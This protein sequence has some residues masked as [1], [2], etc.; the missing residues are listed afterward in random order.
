MGCATGGRSAGKRRRGLNVPSSSV[1]RTARFRDAVVLVTGADGG[2]GRAIVERF[3]G[4]G[5]R[6][7]CADATVSAAT[8]A[9]ERARDA[10]AADAIGLVADLA[11]PEACER[12]VTEAVEWG[13]GID[14]LVNNAGLMR[15]GDA[16][17]TSDADW[18]AVMSVNV[19]AVFR[20]CRAAIPRMSERGGGAIVNLSSRW[21]VDPGPGHLAYA[22]SKAAVAAM[23]RCLARDHG[24]AGIRVNAVCPNEVDTPMLRSGFVT[25][26]LD[27]A[28]A[29]TSLEQTIP[30]GRVAEPSDIADAIAFL[31]SHDARYVTGT[32]LDLAGG[33]TPA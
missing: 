15:R 20:L 6:V 9:A 3:A 4:E 18:S 23:T 8:A 28:E 14:I 19:D 12:L 26:G 16:V 27:P 30:F 31:A 22:T 11:E 21:G 33:K 17:A 2:I 29:I 13:G 10:G 7:A 25:R 5:A 24:A 1:D 32:L